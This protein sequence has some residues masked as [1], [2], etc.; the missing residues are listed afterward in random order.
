MGDGYVGIVIVTTV[1]GRLTIEA[2]KLTFKI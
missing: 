1:V 2:E